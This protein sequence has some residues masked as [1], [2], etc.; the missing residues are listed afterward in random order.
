MKDKDF[1]DDYDLSDEEFDDDLYNED[2]EVIDESY[3]DFDTGYEESASNYKIWLDTEPFLNQIYL[4]LTNQKLERIRIVKNDNITYKNKPVPL[5]EGIEPLANDLG[6]SQIMSLCRTFLSAPLVQGNFDKDGY[7]NQMLSLS[8]KIN[9][10]VFSNRINWGIKVQDVS[11]ILTIL[12]ESISIF[13]TRTI[14]NL[15]RARDRWDPNQRT[16]EKK[17]LI[18]KFKGKYKSKRGIA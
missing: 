4:S 1:I 10:A 3:N 12:E 7:H 17:G 13:L 2:D 15:E 14:N 18:D 11:L 6:I 16:E 8:V 5:A 9:R